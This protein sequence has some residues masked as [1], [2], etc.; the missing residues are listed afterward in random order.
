M[1]FIFL[2]FYFL[3]LSFG[4]FNIRLLTMNRSKSLQRLL[5]SILKN[6]MKNYTINMEIFVDAVPGSNKIDEKTITVIKNFKWSFGKK[7]VF[8]SKRNVGL[9]NQWLR[10]YNKQEPL[11]ILEDDIIL[12]ESFVPVAVK[13][14]NYLSKINNTNIFGISFQK[15]RLILKSD[16]CKNFE[17]EKCVS[18]YIAKDNV[19]FM[20]QMAT[21]AP[22]VFSNKW[23]ELIRYYKN[24]KIQEEKL[25]HCIPG[26]IANL[27][28]NTSG[29]FM[30]YFFYVK[31]YFMLYFSSENNLALNMFENGVHF[32][33]KTKLL[34]DKCMN[35][36]QT[37]K[38]IYSTK[39][40]Y[41][42]GFNSMNNA[43]FNNFNL[44][45]KNITKDI[46][47][48]IKKFQKN[49]KNTQDAHK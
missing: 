2:N 15:L 27:W 12:C 44:E 39:Y 42:Y 41:D 31:K 19:F 10:F 47:C 4:L 46:K 37:E 34:N 26:S 3:S 11:L 22:M 1:L 32:K 45:I 24:S 23:N 16:N 48:N 20:M 35:F 8:L 6:E 14:L 5:D 30:Q 43:K 40:F 17:P 9:K 29:T 49:P 33:K 18:K 21:W 25:I 13:S 36:S 28:Y 7:E 38:I